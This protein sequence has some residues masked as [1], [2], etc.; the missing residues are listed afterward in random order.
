MHL[1]KD[2]YPAR[3]LFPQIGTVLHSEENLENLPV[4]YLK[5]LLRG[6]YS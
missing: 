4:F 6:S 1:L 2:E 5:A 3:E